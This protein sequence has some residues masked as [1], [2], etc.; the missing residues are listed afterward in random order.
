MTPFVIK[1]SK[2]KLSVQIESTM[3]A[4]KIILKINLIP[5]LVSKKIKL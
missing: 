1:F 2:N 3:K 5:H 4:E